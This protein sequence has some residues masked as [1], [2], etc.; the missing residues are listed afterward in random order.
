MDDNNPHIYKN[1]LAWRYKY[2]HPDIRKI[3][4]STLAINDLYKETEQWKFALILESTNKDDKIRKTHEES[5]REVFT[6][7]GLGKIKIRVI[8]CNVK[9]TKT[10]NIINDDINITLVNSGASATD[11]LSSNAI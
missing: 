2:T 1:L 5:L 4:I 11:S 10:T 7:I 8:E 6:D 3:T 9:D